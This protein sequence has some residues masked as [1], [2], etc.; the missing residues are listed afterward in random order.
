[1]NYKDIKTYFTIKQ[2]HGDACK[3]IC[4][5]HPDKEASLSIKY[6]RVQG[7]TIL[8]CHA[9]CETKEIVKAA[10]LEMSDLFDKPMD[11]DSGKM[12]IEAVYKYTDE[13]GRVLFEK[14]R[15]KGKKFSQRRIIDGA[16][17]WGL[18]EGIYYE[19]FHS[20][21]AWSMKERKNVKSKKFEGIEP[22]VYNLPGVIE[23]VK[24]N[25]PV[26]IVEGEKDS[27]NLI[28]IGLAATTSFD[29][30]SKSKQN[31][32]WRDSYNK[33]FEG[34]RGIL[35]PDNDN[36]GRAHMKFIAQK[37]SAITEDIKIINLPGI[38]I[39][40]D[41]SDWLDFGGTRDE[42]LELVE[43]AEKWNPALEPENVNLIN[44]NFSD[45]GNAERLITM[46]N[47]IIRYKPGLKR[48]WWFI[49]SG[50]YWQ[51]DCVGKIEVLARSVIK[52][53]QQQ[54]KE[55]P[56]STEDI[57]KQV[58]KFVLRSENDNHI[59]AMINQ[60]RTEHN[61]VLSEM[62]KDVYLLNLRNGT[63]NLKT[64]ELQ[65]HN[66]KDY[67]TRLVNVDFKPGATCPNWVEF[68]DKIFM[69]NKEL[70]EYIQKSIG[71]SMTGDANLQC[72][73]ILH[74]Q[75]SNGKGTFMKAVMTILGDYSATLKGNSL[76]EKIG[77]EGARGDL[78]KLE[79]KYFVCVNEL[80]E[81]K[82]FDEALVK[83]L[84]SGAD[85]VVP[86]R[87]MYEEEF[88]LHPTFKLWM[89]TNKL[90][91][92]KGTDNG[93]WRRVRKIPFEYNFEN[94]PEKDEH[95]F[96]NKLMPEMSGIL[97]WA[98]EGCLKWQKEGMKVPD[99]VKYA[100]DDYKN[101]MDPVQRFIDDECIVS[102]TC[103]VKIS[104]LY[105]CYT[106][107]S[108]ENKEYVLSTIKLSKRLVEKG[109]KKE[110]NKHG[111]Y[112]QGIGIVDTEHQEEFTEV[113]DNI[114]PFDSK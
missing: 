99:D 105:T 22:V 43:S 56:Q 55:L 51:P 49:W 90:P 85:E 54:G 33:Y 26:F 100:I 46:Y 73:Y 37:L 74:G 42:L 11:K 106:D 2:E 76:M 35:L 77:D 3:A 45:V 18:E 31:Q 25:E 97:N 80:E 44:F 88:D 108:H 89:T 64:G 17:V 29:G 62:N 102:E 107:W 91:R 95:F 101:E 8:K 58:S 59:R 23:A 52:S 36:P 38:E 66:R 14:V 47:K 114:L 87:R 67:I 41:V 72:F 5:S 81:R 4:P 103:K 112:W 28:R 24:N 34:A 13:S 109:F 20:S 94:D 19:T 65:E 9:G 30:A 12:S 93:I 104:E 111:R 113:H 6:D 63:L 50:K 16:T 110:R 79:G 71:Y 61:I 53:L 78:A 82:C 57:K 92:I 84:T 1:M 96:E 48:S 10:G 21:N 86:V 70:I 60:A 75:G 98:L 32:K 39:K 15:F 27:D 69:G 40:E 83:S 68:V 7:K